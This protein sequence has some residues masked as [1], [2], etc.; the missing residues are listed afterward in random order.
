[1]LFKQDYISL[2]KWPMRKHTLDRS[3]ADVRMVEIEMYSMKFT[4]RIIYEQSL[5]KKDKMIQGSN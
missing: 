4:Y 3:A 5:T 2:L 1:M